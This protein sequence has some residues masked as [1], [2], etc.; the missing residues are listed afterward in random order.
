[1]SSNGAKT[2]SAEELLRLP[3]RSRGIR[4]G[5]PTDL[6]VDIGGRRAIGLELVCGDDSLRFL[7]LAAATLEDREIAVTSAL[8]LLDRLGADFYRR[9]AEGFRALRGTPVARD[10]EQVGRL[11]DLVV[12]RGGTIREVAVARDG[13]VARV[14]LDDRVRLEQRAVPVP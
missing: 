2:F 10:G 7:P 12:D 8:M 1:V 4:L 14:P 9:R 13:A 6:L 3:V 11:V 5:R